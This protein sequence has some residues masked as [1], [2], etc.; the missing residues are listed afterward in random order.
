MS[1][2]R[3]IG[4]D[5]PRCRGPLELAAT[6]RDVVWEFRSLEAFNDQP[7]AELA[8]EYDLL[9]VDHPHVAAAAEAGALAPL[10]T[11]LAPEVLA[12]RAADS[13]GA[14]F[15]SYV[16]AG[17]HWALPIDAACQVSA[18][19]TDLLAAARRPRPQTWDHALEL[20]R[21][22]P[23]TVALPL[24]PADAFCSLLTLCA[25]RGAPVLLEAGMRFDRG[26]VELLVELAA[27]VD[28]IS[29]AAA[30]PELLRRLQDEDRLLYV[31]LVFGYTGF[32]RLPV[33][34]G[35]PPRLDG[36][37]GGPVLG[38][39][40]L[41][42]S[43]RSASVAEAADLCAWLAGEDAQR[44]VVLAAGG[45]P[46]SAAVWSDVR[47]DAA[48]GGFFSATG[49]A[50]ASAYVRPRHPAWPAFQEEAGRSLAAALAEARDA[51]ATLA[52]L[53][54]LAEAT[55]RRRVGAGDSVAR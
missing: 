54:D 53:D 31:P 7:P 14:S 45:Q 4:W 55:V 27:L 8:D 24:R 43:A 34:F 36:G 38:G 51:D 41:A 15:S 10:D 19:R 37:Q 23:G 12:D 5:H 3:G 1:A 17:H 33:A 32:S 29:F 52:V 50:L 30:P 20:A 40:G 49:A 25:Q 9:V 21:E 47:A 26:A 39:A 22:L 42:V 28:E 48:V 13:A 16:Y 18:A 44:E 11:L 35:A 6:R 46:A 2:L